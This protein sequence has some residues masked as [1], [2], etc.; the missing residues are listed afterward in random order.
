MA[1]YGC[2]DEIELLPNSLVIIDGAVRQDVRF[3]TVENS[4]FRKILP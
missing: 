1:V 2:D 3:Y 4:N